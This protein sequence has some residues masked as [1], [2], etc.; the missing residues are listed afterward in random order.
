MTVCERLSVVTGGTAA[1]AGREVGEL[2]GVPATTGAD[3]TP[4]GEFPP[5]P[6]VAGEAGAKVDTLVVCAGDAGVGTRVTVF[7]TL[8]MM[9][10]FWAT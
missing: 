4:T 2:P 9:P 3:V 6:E 8:V 10:G 1:P 5:E 7:G